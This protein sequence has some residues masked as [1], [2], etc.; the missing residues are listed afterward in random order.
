MLRIRV[1]QIQVLVLNSRFQSGNLLF[2]LV[3][4]AFHLLLLV[5][6]ALS[7][8]THFLE[9]RFL[10]CLLS[11]VTALVF[12]YCFILQDDVVQDSKED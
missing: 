8:D 2:K 10:F 1:Q 11:E 4:F 6:D 7:E 5:H 3:P 9:H 12:C